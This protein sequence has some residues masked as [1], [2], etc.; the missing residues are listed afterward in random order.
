MKH[1]Q[2]QKVKVKVTRSRNVVARKRQI[3]PVNIRSIL[4]EIEIARAI[5]RV[6]LLTR[7]S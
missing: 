7:S 6:R 5:G 1:C 3:F 4:L 2:G